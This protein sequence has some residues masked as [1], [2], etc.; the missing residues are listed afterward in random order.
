M[1][2]EVTLTFKTEG[3]PTMA[4][5]AMPARNKR[6]MVYI[7]DLKEAKRLNGTMGCV[8]GN[9]K[10]RQ[11]VQLKDGS[12]VLI[13]PENATWVEEVRPS[14]KLEQLDWTEAG[15]AEFLARWTKKA[16]QQD[17]TFFE[18]HGKDVYSYLIA[19]AFMVVNQKKQIGKAGIIFQQSAPTECI[20]CAVWCSGRSCEEQSSPLTDRK[21]GEKWW[22]CI[23][24]DKPDK[25]DE[26]LCELKLPFYCPVLAMGNSR[27]WWVHPSRLGILPQ[28]SAQK[29][30]PPPPRVPTALE[31]CFSSTVAIE[32][33]SNDM[34]QLCDSSKL[35]SE[36]A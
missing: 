21:A 28:R 16:E 9:D 22:P 18:Q 34:P 6:K 13:K 5:Q 11:L 26:E 8:V 32:E 20:P 19:K 24:I 35:P 30:Q 27:P 29:A 15:E 33:L 25:N 1:E 4:A 10:G 31:A 12:R 7:H 3:F 14:G 2:G 36:E 17:P 23:V